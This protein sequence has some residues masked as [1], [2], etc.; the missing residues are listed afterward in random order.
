MKRLFDENHEWSEI[1]IGLDKY[2]KACL[3]KWV[4]ANPGLDPR[5]VQLFHRRPDKPRPNAAR[6]PNESGTSFPFASSAARGRPVQR[7]TA[8]LVNLP[9]P[10]GMRGQEHLADSAPH[11]AEHH[12]CGVMGHAQ[13]SGHRLENEAIYFEPELLR[14]F[15]PQEP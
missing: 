12:R 7:E 5:D 14:E 4:T 10:L 11:P 9:D 15:L 1:A 3:Q 13:Y 6:S 2:I 8:S